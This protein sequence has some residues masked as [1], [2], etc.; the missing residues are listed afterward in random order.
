MVH[1]GTGGVTANEISTELSLNQEVK[2][3]VDVCFV[4]KRLLITKCMYVFK[5]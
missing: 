3:C 5:D 1:A 4:A 2:N